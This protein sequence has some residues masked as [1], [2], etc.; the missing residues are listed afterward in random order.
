M[1]SGKLNWTELDRSVQFSWVQF[2]FPVCI[3]PATSCDDRRSSSPVFVQRQTSHWLAD[4]RGCAPDCE[5]PA[6]T[7]NF[8]SESS[9]V[10][11]TAENLT[12]LNSSVELSWVQF[13]AVLCIGLKFGKRC[14]SQAGPAAWNCL[15]DSIKLAT[16][17]N[18]FKNIL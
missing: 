7:A 1:H 12:E 17:T 3:E 10:Q 18:R 6:T 13:P 16:D 2:S 4:S 14:F 11:C 8:V 5:E 15:P 9:P